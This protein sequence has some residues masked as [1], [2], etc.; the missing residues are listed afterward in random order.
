L[1]LFCILLVHE[2]GTFMP[3]SSV[4][5]LLMLRALYRM[6]YEKSF[7]FRNSLNVSTKCKAIFNFF[8]NVF[9]F[10]MHFCWEWH[11]APCTLSDFPG[12]RNLSGLNDLNSLNNFSGLNDL[13]SLISSKKLLGYLSWSLNVG[14]ILKNPLFYWFLPPFLFEAVEGAQHKKNKNWWIRHKFPYLMKT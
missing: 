6:I 14:W 3:N 8:F 2:I 9:S 12:I 11:L 4:S 10:F 7:F 5:I 1:L 13:Y